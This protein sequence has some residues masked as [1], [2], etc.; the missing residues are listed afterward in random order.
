MGRNARLI[1]LTGP[2]VGSEAVRAGDLTPGQLRGP[3]VR[4]LYRDIYSAAAEPET[5]LLYCRG[6]ALFLP[7]EA[8]ITGRSAA[9]VR[10]VGLA[11]A[12]DPV[13]LVVPRPMR[14]A[15]GG[16]LRTRRASTTPGEREPWGP[17]GLAVPD[18]MALDLLLERP[19]SEAVADL[20]AVLRAHLVDREPFARMLAC[21][22]DNG[23]RHARRAEELADPLAESRPESRM[24]VLLVLD[25]LEPVPQY[26]VSDERGRF[27]R[28]D[29]AFP[30]LLLAVEYD[31]AWREGDRWA[32]ARDRERLNRLHAAG[33]EVVFVTAALLRDPREL[34]RVV[35]AA[36]HRR[37]AHC[38]TMTSQTGPVRRLKRRSRHDRVNCVV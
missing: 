16:R 19:L 12:R 33:W 27:A 9:T 35:R 36:A 34:V 32:L 28:P 4:R 5:H 18:R 1:D 37:L 20:D 8:V 30:D 7:P 23:I 21:R 22:H 2:F 10:G 25:G 29:L 11:A 3:G 38:G 24:R 14:I 17:I 15:N 26:W 31:G 6:A 13:E